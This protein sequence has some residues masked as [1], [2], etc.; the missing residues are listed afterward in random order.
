[1]GY[2]IL[3]LQACQEDDLNFA[4]TGATGPKVTTCTSLPSD[5]WT[6]V[7]DSD[8]FQSGAMSWSVVGDGIHRLFLIA[9]FS[10]KASPQCI[11][12]CVS[13]AFAR[14]HG[15]A[16]LPYCGLYCRVAGKRSLPH[17]FPSGTPWCKSYGADST[18]DCH[19]TTV[20]EAIWTGT[21]AR[22]TTNSAQEGSGPTV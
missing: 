7:G 12:R 8:N 2:F 18:H 6:S 4:A 3:G 13:L 15:D 17:V 14:I 16:L 9:D 5:C 10:P 20:Q 1:M 11:Q 19:A 21:G 22:F